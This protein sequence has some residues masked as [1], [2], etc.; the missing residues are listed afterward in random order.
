MANPGW[1]TNAQERT[2]GRETVLEWSNAQVVEKSRVVWQSPTVPQT[3]TGG[4]GATLPR[5]S[6]D[7]LL[8]N[9]AN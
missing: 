5:C 8:R 1:H 4:L 3:D 2:E 7:P 6:G 9:S